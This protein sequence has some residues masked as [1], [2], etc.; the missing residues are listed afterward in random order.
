MFW[1]GAVVFSPVFFCFFKNTWFM[2]MHGSNQISRCCSRI[3]LF[4]YSISRDD[5][6]DLV[7]WSYIHKLGMNFTMSCDS[8][9]P[10]IINDDCINSRISVKYPCVIIIWGPLLV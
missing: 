1:Q 4:I 9:T 2:P 3:N 5:I 7:K 10:L 6:T 8:I